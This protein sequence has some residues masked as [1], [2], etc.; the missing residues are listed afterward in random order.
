[1]FEKRVFPSIIGIS[2]YYEN[3]RYFE[4]LKEYPLTVKNIEAAKSKRDNI[5]YR[6]SVNNFDYAEEFPN[7]K[8]SAKFPSKN[9]KIPMVKS[10]VADLIELKTLQKA[11]SSYTSYDSKS[12]HILA[13]WA[14]YPIDK[15]APSE[16][17]RWIAKDLK[18]LSNKTINDI[19]IVFRGVYNSA[20]K[21][22]V[23]KHTPFEHIRNLPVIIK[24][25]EPFTIEEIRTIMAFETHQQ[26]EINAFV[27]QC[28]TGVRPSELIALTWDDVD[29]ENWTIKVQ[30]GNVKSRYKCTKTKGSTRT[31]SLL[32]PAIKILKK[33]MKHSYFKAEKKVDVLQLDNKTIKK[34]KLR[35][36]FLN[37]NTE[38]AFPC[39]GS[40]T[41]RFFKKHL[42]AAGVRYRAFGQARHT[43]A[44]QLLT[45]GV[46]QHWLAQ[47]MGHTSVKMIEKH[48][49]RWM[50]EEVPYMASHVSSLLENMPEK[51]TKLKSDQP[52]K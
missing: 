20:I 30:R 38:A 50:K 12:K 27:F 14:D 26:Q 49:G 43:F 47:Q 2:F 32:E 33:Q 16:I 45:A 40:F 18:V 52:T 19:M 17:E 3:K 37:T 8:K 48:Y 36:I 41:D 4:V 23:M 28:Y 6:I 1:L 24:E 42:K 15:I 5:M 46:N 51:P 34:E 13:K 22:G 29:R 44:S 35:M 11:H 31:I 7:S 39:I 9:K 21:D 10:A 25:P